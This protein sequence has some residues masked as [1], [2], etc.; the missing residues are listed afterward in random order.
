MVLLI[1]TTSTSGKILGPVKSSIKVNLSDLGFSIIS[2]GVPTPSSKSSFNLIK[3]AVSNNR[4]PRVVFD[5]LSAN[6][7]VV[8]VAISSTDANFSE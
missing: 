2:S 3:P 6:A 1:K 7:I 5:G 4:N 8:P